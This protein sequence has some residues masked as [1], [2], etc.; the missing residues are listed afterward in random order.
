MYKGKIEG[1]ILSLFESRCEDSVLNCCEQMAFHAKEKEKIIVYEPITRRIGLP[2]VF[3]HI[4][5][6][7]VFH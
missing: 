6:L 7:A 5:R 3:P 4:F 2:L 1:R